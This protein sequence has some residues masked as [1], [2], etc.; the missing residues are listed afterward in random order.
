MERLTTIKVLCSLLLGGM[1]IASCVDDN[2]DLSDI[3]MTLQIGKDGSLTLP[4]SSTGDIKLENLF[5]LADDGPITKVT[6]D[7]KEFYYM[8]Q[9]GNAE[10]AVINIEDITIP[11]PE[12]KDFKA[13]LLKEDEISVKAA[14]PAIADGTSVFYYNF[15]DLA[16]A[17]IPIST[18]AGINE[19]VKGLTHI[20][21][22]TESAEVNFS[23]HLEKYGH[24]KTVH[25]D[26]LALLLPKGMEIVDDVEYVYQRNGQTMRQPGTLSID[27]NGLP[28]VT[29]FDGEDEGADAAS[30][31]TITM[32]IKGA[33]VSDDP[34]VSD[35]IFN[36]EDHTA[37]LDSKIQMIGYMRVDESDLDLSNLTPEEMTKVATE[38][39]SA[40][41]PSDVFYVGGGNFKS[42]LCVETFS[43]ALEHR[44]TDINDIELN[45]I[46][47]FLDD[48][49]VELD[50]TN[51]QLILIVKSDLQTEASTRIK[52]NAYR[53]GEMTARGLDT[54]ILSL[55]GRSGKTIVKI[56]AKDARPEAVA[57]PDEYKDGNYILQGQTVNNIGDIIRRVPDKIEI[58]GVDEQ[59]SIVVSLPNCENLNIRQDYNIDL[60]Y[61]IYCPLSFGDNFQIIYHEEES[62]WDIGTSLDDLDF[63]SLTIDATVTSDLP[64]AL[65]LEGTPI[66]V[67]GSDI[68]NKCAIDYYYQDANGTYQLY[69][70]QK[71]NI[72]AKADGTQNGDNI[73]LVIHNKDSK[74]GMKEI[75]SSSA[76][77]KQLDGL[78]Y[79]A[80]MKEPV[81]NTEALQTQSNL[82]LTNVK[83]TL[84]GGVTYDAN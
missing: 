43:G 25:Y 51:P 22:D 16:T 37:H 4:K 11:Q 12:I 14:E 54:G 67:D 77:N 55:D 57:I 53:N 39:N 30:A 76:G 21:F 2:Y 78:K 28:K 72:R 9:S 70:P 83:I 68:S 56:L 13:N 81:N 40:L 82:V 41:I 46:P 47:D 10:Q 65:Y 66:S 61:R 60:S 7:G 5:D 74:K 44:I 35:F 64:L 52:L 29:F 42:D 45:D 58:V 32:K 79:V 34:T 49:E 6:V 27:E 17:Y 24:L 69:N 36:P 26:N 84:T 19:D 80:T 63:Q 31:A 3:D 18:S 48:D 75:L 15:E 23:V 73:R 59:K 38:G 33:N 62:G 8:D 71:I 1:V 50:L 20:T